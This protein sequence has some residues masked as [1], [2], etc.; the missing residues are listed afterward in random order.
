M[1][2]EH[3]NMEISVQMVDQIIIEVCQLVEQLFDSV[4]LIFVHQGYQGVLHGHKGDQ[5]LKHTG[6]L[7]IFCHTVCVKIDAPVSVGTSLPVPFVNIGEDNLFLPVVGIIKQHQT[8]FYHGTADLRLI[9]PVHAKH[10]QTAFFA[11]L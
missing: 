7:H 11:R 5:T 1:E 9:F 10:V 4:L 2:L 8:L 6:K 3:V